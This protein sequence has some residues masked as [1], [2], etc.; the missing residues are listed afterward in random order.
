LAVGTV[1]LTVLV[2]LIQ[3]RTPVPA[4]VV[5]DAAAGVLADF[6]PDFTF[7]LA[8]APAH[9]EDRLDDS[10]LDFAKRGKVR[11]CDG[12]RLGRASGRTATTAAWIQN[13]VKTRVRTRI[14]AKRI[15]S[16]RLRGREEYDRPFPVA[17]PRWRDD[18][19]AGH[20]E[21]M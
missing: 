5:S 12:E 20:V 1:L 3:S 16:E 11:Y 21:G 10:W 7:G 15:P 14:V 9:V 18:G 8:T 19:S 13:T 6:G 2:G 17:S 4:F